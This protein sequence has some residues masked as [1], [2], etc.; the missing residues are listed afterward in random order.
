MLRIIFQPNLTEVCWFG[1][2]TRH[3]IVAVHLGE[4]LSSRRYCKSRGFFSHLKTFCKWFLKSIRNSLDTKITLPCSSSEPYILWRSPFIKPTTWQSS[5]VRLTS[6]F[7]HEIYLFFFL[8]ALSNDYMTWVVLTNLLTTTEPR[9]EK[10]GTF[11]K[12]S[13][14]TSV[15][16]TITKFLR[17]LWPKLLRCFNCLLNHVYPEARPLSQLHQLPMCLRRQQHR[18]HLQKPISFETRKQTN[19]QAFLKEQFQTSPRF[20]Y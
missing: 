12:F 9:K 4:Y 10:S 13:E 17:W 8:K 11:L 19:K 20:Q 7:F 18:L 14:R 15:G 16:K 2:R 3:F 5:T 6:Y 1:V